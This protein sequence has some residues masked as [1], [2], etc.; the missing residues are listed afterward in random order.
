MKKSVLSLLIA[1]MA[2]VVAN[3]Q[4]ISVV[5]DGTTSLY[6][7]LQEAIENA[8][9]GCVIYL[10][11]GRFAIS[12]AVKITKKLT[13]IGIGHYL[14]NEGS[15]E[16]STRIEGNLWFNE[17]S[18]GSSVMACYI[19]GNVNIGENDAEV[20]DL[21]IKFCNLKG[22][23]VKNNKCKEMLV[24]QCYVR[25]GGNFGQS[26]NVTISN[27]VLREINYVESGLISNNVITDSGYG[28]TFSS[29][30]NCVIVGNIIRGRIIIGL[31]GGCSSDQNLAVG[32]SYGDNPIIIDA[33][34]EDLFEKINNWQVTPASNFHFKEAYRQYESQV[35]LY[36]GSGFNDKQLA[37]IPYIVDHQVD[38]ETDASGKL[39]IRI[40]VKASE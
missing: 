25:E 3:A 22:V 17:N 40:R 27:S 34:E 6:G 7:T 11:G 16:G 4:Q 35:G 19:T 2:I 9:P 20:N 26:Q 31:G 30:N 23:Q 28:T 10:P 24:N 29:V 5:S 33:T 38:S 39:N 37:P 13:I 14:S 15:E 12:D 36:S 1:L 32:R 21:T 8:E 18:S